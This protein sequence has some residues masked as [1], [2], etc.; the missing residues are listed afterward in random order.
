[1]HAHPRSRRRRPRAASRTLGD[2]SKASRRCVRAPPER[3]SPARRAARPRPRE[4]HRERKGIEMRHRSRTRSSSSHRQTDAG[5][6][7][8]TA[9]VRTW[10]RTRAS[11]EDQ[12]AGATH[13][14]GSARSAAANGWRRKASIAESACLPDGL[15]AH[16]WRSPRRRLGPAPAPARSQRP[17][18]PYSSSRHRRSP[19][20]RPPPRCSS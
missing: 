9:A 6:M 20:H 1:M 14:E 15:S 12:S 17:R 16:G 10:G 7:R 2:R 5:P 3:A 11:S 19:L 8:R 13:P 18:W 4:T